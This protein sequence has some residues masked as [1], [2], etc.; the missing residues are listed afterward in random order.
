MQDLEVQPNYN[1]GDKSN[2]VVALY[3]KYALLRIL[4]IVLLDSLDCK[5]LYYYEHS[6]R[7][8]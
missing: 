3:K 5:V 7:V 2:C 1:D 6:K 8:A 4:F